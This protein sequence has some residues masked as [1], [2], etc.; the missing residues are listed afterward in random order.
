VQLTNLQ[1]KA[2]SKSKQKSAIN[3]NNHEKK[4][5]LKSRGLIMDE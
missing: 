5:L 1:T 3:Q 4:D 2:T